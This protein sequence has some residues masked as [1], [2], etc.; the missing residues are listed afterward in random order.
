MKQTHS[1]EAPATHSNYVSAAETQRL[2]AL[3]EEH[4]NLAK[5]MQQIKVESEALYASLRSRIAPE[6]LGGLSNLPFGIVKRQPVNPRPINDKLSISAGRAIVSSF[7]NKK[8]H[9]QA[10]VAALDA[11]TKVAKKYGLE[12]LPGPVVAA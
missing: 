6:F 11:A 4:N 2:V 12:E 5:R 3:E 8:T 9:Q 10:K 7:R 1:S